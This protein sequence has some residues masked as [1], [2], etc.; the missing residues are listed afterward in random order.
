MPDKK[1]S[2]RSSYRL[3]VSLEP[4]DHKELSQ[5]AK[6]NKVSVAWVVREA[7]RRLLKEELPLLHVGDE[8]DQS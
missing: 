4:G 1:D 8:K 3:S 7:V 2:A 5:I 6:R